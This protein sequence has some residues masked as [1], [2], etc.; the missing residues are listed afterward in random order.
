MK[1]NIIKT[2][3]YIFIGITMVWLFLYQPIPADDNSQIYKAKITDLVSDDTEDQGDIIIRKLIY[4]A[5]ITDDRF[6]DEIVPVEDV[7]ETNEPYHV[8]AEEDDE[9]LVY[10]VFNENNQPVNSYIVKFIRTNYIIVL[11]GI[12]ILLLV[13]IGHLKGL[14]ALLALVLTLL[15]VFKVLLPQILAGSDP[16]IVSILVTVIITVFSLLL[17][18]GFHKKTYAAM[19]GTLAGVL[20]GGGLAILVSSQAKVLGLSFEEAQFIKFAAH[21]IKMNFSGLLFASILLGTLGAV[22]DVCMSIASSI[23]EIKHVSPFISNKELFIAGMNVGKDVMGTM[24]NTLILAYAGSSLLLMLMYLGYN[25]PLIE[26]INDDL[27]VTE[28]IRAL[29][30]TI[31]LISAIPITALI[32]ASITQTETY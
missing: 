31:G 30:G 19:I 1:T 23:E 2:L 26:I 21:D 24:I 6:K 25:I 32:A 29:A 20:V 18:S 14:K 22:M 5:I 10:L 13:V 28:I 4:N 9:V 15:L 17:I 7:F 3:I 27:V 11:V 16:V 8:F 12:F